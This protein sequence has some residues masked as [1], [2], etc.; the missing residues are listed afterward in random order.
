MHNQDYVHTVHTYLR[1]SISV[2]SFG[3]LCVIKH[4]RSI[5]DSP[6]WCTK[7]SW[8]VFLILHVRVF[9]QVG[10][11]SQSTETGKSLSL[12]FRKLRMCPI[13]GLCQNIQL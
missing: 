4:F 12:N 13:V 6:L 7:V 11:D 5:H 2:S 10:L 1:P 3:N 8:H 9:V